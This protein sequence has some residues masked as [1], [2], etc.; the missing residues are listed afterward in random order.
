[1]PTI[2]DANEYLFSTA[3]SLSPYMNVC[4]S[5]QTSFTNAGIHHKK[6]VGEFAEALRKRDSNTC[7]RDMLIRRLED[8]IEEPEKFV[9]NPKALEHINDYLTTI[10]DRHA[11]MVINLPKDISKK[12]IIKYG[13]KLSNKMKSNSDIDLVI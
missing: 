7:L 8:L 2:V 11:E 6:V 5:G 1:M 4:A 12:N 9:K 3:L 13:E 10:V